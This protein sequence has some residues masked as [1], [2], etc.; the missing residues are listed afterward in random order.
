MIAIVDDDGDLRDGLES[1][2]QSFGYRTSTFG[3]AEDFLRCE[4]LQDT[5]CVITDVQM[6]G[7]TGFDLQNR[8]DSEGYRIPIIFITGHPDDAVRRRALKSGA[9]G[10]LGKPFNSGVLIRHV[11]KALEARLSEPRT[12]L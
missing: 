11:E 8:L 4:K 12:E 9:V 2:L 5:S 6:P 1:L 7:L 10:F 3:S